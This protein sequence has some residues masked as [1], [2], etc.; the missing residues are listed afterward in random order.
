MLLGPQPGHGV[1]VPSLIKL[2]LGPYIVKG[3]KHIFPINIAATHPGSDLDQSDAL[4]L[5]YFVY[6]SSFIP[7][8]SLDSN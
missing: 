2:C 7:A 5:I 1:A 3:F 6:F 4:L 8:A